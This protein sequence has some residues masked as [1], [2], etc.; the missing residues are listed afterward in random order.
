M[1]LP[2]KTNTV[3]LIALASVI[4]AGEK[5][6]PETKVEDMTKVYTPPPPPKSIG[7]QML[8]SKDLA[9]RA[10]IQARVAFS[11]E[12]A[13]EYT[14]K[15]KQ[16]KV[17]QQPN[18]F[19]PGKAVRAPDGKIFPFDGIHRLDAHKRNKE[20]MEFELFETPEG[21]DAAKYA[22]ALALGVNQE[23]GLKRTN[24]DKQ[25]AVKTAFTMFPEANNMDVSRLTGVSEK[26]VRDYRPAKPASSAVRTVTRKGKTQKMNTSR[27]GTKA[28]KKSSSEKKGKGKK[29]ATSTES[30]TST[31]NKGQEDSVKAQRL[32]AAIIKIAGAQVGD[33][34]IGAVRNALEEGTL[35]LSAGDISDWADTSTDRIRQ[36]TPLIVDKQMKPKRAFDFIDKEIT[37]KTT[38]D[39]L[40]LLILTHPKARVDKVAGLKVAI[41]PE[42]ISLVLDKKS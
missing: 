39:D 4:G 18:P 8:S 27:I 30:A 2:R 10:G 28:G 15:L 22:Q 13:D 24:K 37:G 41:E 16:V 36:V 31:G 34:Q 20:D 7:V 35:N 25:F 3:A 38:L 11:Q 19:P 40:A 33:K 5:S 21:W 6:T 26:M 29:G 23:H 42:S 1:T 14:E 9:L 17:D 32:R 12:T